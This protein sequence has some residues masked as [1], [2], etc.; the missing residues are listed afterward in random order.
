MK[1]IASVAPARTEATAGFVAKADQSSNN[2]EKKPKCR[3]KT[4]ILTS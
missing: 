2:D 1:S 4:Y 3:Q